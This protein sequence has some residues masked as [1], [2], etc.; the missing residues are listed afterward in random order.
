[1]LF[2]VY[3]TFNGEVIARKG[4]SAR[5]LDGFLRAIGKY[6]P[7]GDGHGFEVAIPA[8]YA[9]RLGLTEF[10]GLLHAPGL[11]A[12]CYGEIQKA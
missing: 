2:E 3:R 9:K 1:M 4:H 6:Q 10:N 7:C 8:A 11:G 12:V 5:T